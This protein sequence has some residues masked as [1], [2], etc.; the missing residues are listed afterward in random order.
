MRPI[1]YYHPACYTSY[2]FLRAVRDLE[3]DIELVNLSNDLS[4]AIIKRILTVPLIEISGRYVY[5][6]PINL[7]LAIRL[8]KEGRAE[9][10]V[11]DPLESLGIA[12]VDSSAASSIVVTSGSLEQILKFEDFI[13]AATG[14]ELDPEGN[15]KLEQMKN[16]LRDGEASRN[17]IEKWRPKMIATLVY[18]AVRERLYLGYPADITEDDA[19]LWLIAKSSIGRAGVPFWDRVQLIK[20]SAREM[21]QYYEQ[22][23][24]KITEK[25]RREIDEIKAF[26]SGLYRS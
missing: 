17:F 22:R 25:L 7:D 14:L 19:A 6:G 24:E 16:I 15:E 9:L 21:V 20:S 8:L 1:V 10:R 23:K 5:G 12:L 13:K 18:N 2:T 26:Y 4:L 3:L 11:A